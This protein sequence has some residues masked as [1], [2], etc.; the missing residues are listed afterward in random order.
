MN[1]LKK[2]VLFMVG[3]TL[4]YENKVRR[5]PLPSVA[6]LDESRYWVFV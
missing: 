1:Y 6:K 5:L 2:E 4:V 3:S